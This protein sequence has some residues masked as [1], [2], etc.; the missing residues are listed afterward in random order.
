MSETN[1][2]MIRE[3]VEKLRTWL[4]RER[5]RPLC[6][7]AGADKLFSGDDVAVYFAK[8]DLALSLLTA[9]AD[10]LVRLRVENEYLQNCLT[11]ERMAGNR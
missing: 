8:L 2:P 9:Q 5:A 6:E 4:Q 1:E 3:T 11:V 7:Q 10:E